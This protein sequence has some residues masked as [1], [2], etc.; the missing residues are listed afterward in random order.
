L[1]VQRNMETVSA[2]REEFVQRQHELAQSM[3]ERRRLLQSRNEQERDAVETLITRNAVDR[4]TV[5]KTRVAELKQIDAEIAG[6]KRHIFFLPI[7][8]TPAQC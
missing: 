3:A 5:V 1:V 2:L 4:A 8:S 7:I 6:E